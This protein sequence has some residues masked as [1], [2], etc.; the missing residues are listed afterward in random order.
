MAGAYVLFH[1]TRDRAP[2]T[3]RVA[4][5]LDEPVS[6]LMRA[7]TG[8][9]IRHFVD[10][11]EQI[12]EVAH[13]AEARRGRVRVRARHE[14]LHV[15]PQE[16]RARRRLEDLRVIRRDP[17]ARCGA[18]RGVV[19]VFRVWEWADG[20]EVWEGETGFRGVRRHFSWYAGVCGETPVGVGYL[21]CPG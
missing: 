12:H 14:A 6:R 7:R 18:L 3:R 13:G 10:E 16:E 17:R 9:Q 5:R 21:R 11:E 19:R 2:V 20:E 1:H 4:Q 15:A 8:L